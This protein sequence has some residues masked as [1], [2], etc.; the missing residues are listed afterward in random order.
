[1]QL[2]AFS[3]NSFS[4]GKEAIGAN[5]GLVFYLVNDIAR[6]YDLPSLK[7]G[8]LGMAFKAESDDTRASL[9]YKLKKVLNFRAASV[10]T[11]DPYVTGDP[12]LL[13][14]EQVVEQ[15][16]LLILC[17]PHRAYRD[18]DARGK[19]VVDV[20]NVV[21]KAAAVGVGTR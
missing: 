11:T 8:L 7:V 1:M 14:V 19:P 10:L 6:K 3:S 9:S 20:W 5:E 4:L 15:S 13:P 12:E 17:V 16:D 2:V 21:P 18:L